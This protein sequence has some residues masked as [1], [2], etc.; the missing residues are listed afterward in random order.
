MLAVLPACAPNM[1]SPPPAAAEPPP[2]T[3]GFYST[4]QAD[5][6]RRAYRRAC[7]ECHSL[8]DFRGADFEW[9]WRSKTVWD[10][11]R[12]VAFTMPEDNP[13]SLP[14]QTY[15]DVIAY[16]LQLNEYSSGGVELLPRE[17]A[18]DTIPLG[19]GVEKT[20]LPNGGRR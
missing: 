20:R 12:N 1:K 19:P 3:G 13:G 17:G 14:D 6:G 11:Y 8:S 2:A 15:A 18:M 4:E 16:I 10:F 7:R 5:R 9:Q